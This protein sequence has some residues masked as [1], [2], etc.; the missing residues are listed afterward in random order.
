MNNAQATIV[1]KIY[2]FL[3]WCIVHKLWSYFRQWCVRQDNDCHYWFGKWL[4]PSIRKQHVNVYNG[5]GSAH[6]TSLDL[7]VINLSNTPMLTNHEQDTIVNCSIK[8]L[9]DSMTNLAAFI[10][11]SVSHCCRRI[12]QLKFMAIFN[13]L[14]LLRHWQNDDISPKFANVF[15]WTQMVVSSPPPS[16]PSPPPSSPSPSPSPSSSSS[17]SPS[18]SSSVIVATGVIAIV[19]IRHLI[20]R[21]DRNGVYPFPSKK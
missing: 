15:S 11:E 20:S 4:T 17:P 16:S 6:L 7:L 18:P 9:S 3:I 12:I 13:Q 1:L 21:S 19:A 2:V 5:A 8:Y 10:H 14:I